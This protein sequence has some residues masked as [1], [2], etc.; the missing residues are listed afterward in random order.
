MFESGAV[1]KAKNDYVDPKG[2]WIS[3]DRTVRRLGDKDGEQAVIL[4]ASPQC[5]D[6]EWERMYK[7]LAACMNLTQE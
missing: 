3:P 2:Y 7:A 4:S 5:S 1:A 6:A